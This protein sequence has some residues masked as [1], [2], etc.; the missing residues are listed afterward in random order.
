[1]EDQR[2]LPPHVLIFPL[3]LQGPVN[4]MFNLAELLCFS[5][6]HVTVVVT[7]DIHGR[8]LGSTNIQSRFARYQG[9]QLKSIPDG[10]PEDHPRDGNN[11]IELFDSLKSKTKPLFKDMLT[12][13]CLTSE[14]CRRPVS[15]IIADGM[16]GFT[17]DV[18]QE[19]GIPIVYVRTISPCCLWVFFCLP[20][21]I[22]TG[23]LPFSGSFNGNKKFFFFPPFFFI[24]NLM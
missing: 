6:L 12:S 2:K 9:F 22:E 21:L 14:S 19:L 5:G 20:R 18:A 24:F 4:S 11:F 13:G 1:M 8:L 3:P 15:F 16:L 7:E 17:C 23:E 10:L